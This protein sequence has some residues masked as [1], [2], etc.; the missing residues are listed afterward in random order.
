MCDL[1]VRVGLPEGVLLKQLAII[2][3]VI[4]V[5]VKAVAALK[6]AGQKSAEADLEPFPE[7]KW[8][9]KDDHHPFPSRIERAREVD[10]PFTRLADSAR[11]PSSNYG[12]YSP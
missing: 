5:A 4:V 6:K 10:H 1:T 8:P 2:S 11:S 3:G 12:V 7:V 9:K